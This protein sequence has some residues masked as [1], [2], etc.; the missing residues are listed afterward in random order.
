MNS[1][2]SCNNNNYVLFFIFVHLCGDLR[3]ENMIFFLSRMKHM[4]SALCIQGNEL[5][6]PVADDRHSH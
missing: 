2:P 3:A 5:S 4:D 6:K 1:P